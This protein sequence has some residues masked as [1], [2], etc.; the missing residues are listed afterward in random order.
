MLAITPVA[1]RPESIVGRQSE[2]ELL[3]AAL[4][5]LAAGTPACLAV[6]GEPGIGK[7]RFL[8]ELCTRA[9]ERGH[10]VL[11]GSAAEFE[12]DL[13]YGV[14]VEALDAY[15]ASQELAVFT[16]V[17]SGLLS[18]VARVLPS[19]RAENGAP[20]P[21]LGDERHRAHRA[22]RRLLA[23]VAEGDPLVLVLDDLHWSDAAS[24]E[25]I[26]AFV[27]RGMAPR[28]LLGLGCRKG[29][30]P[31][32]LNATLAAPEVT[33]L[34]LGSLSEV[35][36]RR[37]AGEELSRRRHAAIFSESGGNPFYALQLARVAQQPT[38]SSSGDRV[39]EEAGVPRTVAAALVDEL[40][41]LTAP[42]RLL[43]DAGSVAGD[44]FEPELACK[45][46]QLS[47][48]AGMA[49]LDELLHAR[50][51]H[52]TSVPRRFAFRHPIVRRAVYQSTGGG[53]RLAAHAR[54]ASELGARGAPAAAQAHHIE[55]SASQG[56]RTA[57][58]LLLEA[59]T[60]TAPRAPATAARWFGAALR[61]MPEGDEAA[62]LQ[63]LTGLAQ[64]LRSTGDLDR[65]VATLLEALE[66]VPDDDTQQ[67]VTLSAA[68][69]AAENFLGRHV[70][71]KRRLTAALESVSDPE[72]REAVNTLLALV[73][74]A[75]FTQDVDDERAF[76]RR[77]LGAARSLEDPIL[78][79]AAASALAQSAA[80][81][82]ATPETRAG[83]D[84]AAA[85]LDAVTD[86]TLRTPLPQLPG[87]RHLDAV[88]RLAWSEFLIERYDD[89]IEHAARGVAVA[90]STGQ[91]QFGPLIIGAQA[92]SSARRGDLAE[93][94]ALQAEALETAEVAA[95]AYVMCWVLTI[96]AHVAMERGDY[97]DARCTAERAVA[98]MSGLDDNRVAAMACVR[99]AVT[100]RLMGEPAA[101]LDSLVRAAG[102]WDLTRIQPSWRV[103]YA[104]TLTDAELHDG[105]VDDA[106]AFA[107]RA[108]RTAE[109]LG[110]PV[111]T[112]MAQR[113]RAGVRLANG[114]AQMAAELALTSADAA[115]AARAPIEAARS[116]ALAGRAL[117]T[118]GERTRAVPLLR[119]AESTFDAC[120]AERDRQEARHQLRRL[121]ARSEPRGPA[122]GAEAGVAS[123]TRREQE[124][125]GLVTARK[126][127]REIAA[128]L[129]LSEK[130][131]ESH[132]RNIF[133]KLSVSSRVEV[134][135]A[136]EA[137]GGL[138]SDRTHP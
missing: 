3:D 92:L 102:G 34:E 27:R 117:A 69:A 39:A 33:V 105:S 131:I 13:P 40:D 114:D 55:Q 138:A 79:G 64:V 44:P 71:A 8:R 99:F 90:R 65:C 89:A 80:N 5:A 76:A 87:P 136:V 106:D 19:V 1:A 103:H 60:A 67:R 115:A 109:G 46:A 121:G 29:Q 68:C 74:S 10:L 56:D 116:Y 2:L 59:A 45:I 132:L 81:A 16:D 35:D 58:E 51:L 4:E 107:A 42:A 100:R 123:L 82:G 41:A 28:I 50:L 137:A 113:A 111:A 129:F 86:E 7:T 25:L 15:V 49:A 134:A 110:L 83:V 122:T 17:D 18:D 14:W 24:V 77:A 97:D 48:D 36:C 93:A 73:A 108:E 20:T 91:E 21:A 96:S 98:L 30:A 95:N 128:E 31:A 26:G 135:R 70:Q 104:A 120:G 43:L 85:H 11:S 52:T 57:I 118:A 61:L 23:L 133:V 72:S 78:I 32:G 12:R 94:A 54:A 6:E 124:I 75:F 84:E 101:R 53:W 63:T 22:V 125:A 37:L 127:N 47:P 62:R 126:T 130:T 9:E 112:A 88:N 119:S 38:R 66:L